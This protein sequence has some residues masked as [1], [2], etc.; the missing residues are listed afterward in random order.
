MKWNAK[1]KGKRYWFQFVAAR[2]FRKRNFP[3]SLQNQVRR[4]YGR[5]REGGTSTNDGAEASPRRQEHA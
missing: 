4:K 1:K 2:L 3:K 5:Y